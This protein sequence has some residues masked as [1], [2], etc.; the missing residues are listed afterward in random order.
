MVER[1]K[2]RRQFIRVAA[3]QNKWVTPGMVLQAAPQPLDDWAEFGGPRY[4]LTVSK[5][6]GN[7]VI[8]NRARRRLRMVAEEILP[9][10]AETG[11]DYVLIGRK[12]TPSRDFAALRKD[13]KTGLEK[14]GMSRELRNYNDARNKG[15]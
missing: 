13:L 2:S 4:G 14:L 11:Y 5:R 9:G 1:L 10:A 7:A 8:R 12:A 3:E 15:Q 6:V